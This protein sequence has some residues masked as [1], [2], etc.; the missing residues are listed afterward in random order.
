MALAEAGFSAWQDERLE[1][2]PLPCSH[3]PLPLTSARPSP[4]S[5]PSPRLPSGQTSQQ[6]LPSPSDR[7]PS[8]L[9]A[10]QRQ[11]R[12]PGCQEGWGCLARPSRSVTPPVP[13]TLQT[14]DLSGH[15]ATQRQGLSGGQ[16]ACGIPLRSGLLETSKRR[17]EEPYFSQFW[18]QRA[19][20]C[21]HSV[22]RSPGMASK[23]SSHRVVHVS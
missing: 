21:V 16:S 15:P 13:E 4:S 12:R 22:N 18:S 17:K 7:P 3:L 1:W 8:A 6:D 20:G 10:F 14:L 23:K 5:P 11:R 9:A 2:N 19:L